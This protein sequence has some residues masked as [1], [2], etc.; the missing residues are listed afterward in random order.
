M[1][2]LTLG[3]I[4]LFQ[5]WFSWGVFPAV[6]LLDPG[7]SSLGHIS[8]SVV[9]RSLVTTCLTFWRAAKQFSEVAAPLFLHAQQQC[10]F[11]HLYLFE[12]SYPSGCEMVSYCGFW[13]IFSLWLMMLQ[14]FSFAYWPFVCVVFSK[15]SIQVFLPFL[16][17]FYYWFY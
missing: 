10:M 15:M 14:S 9:A 2:Q 5:F 7:F 1:L 13:F 12:C 4:C 17:C 16:K 6:E 3:Y 11:L 8:S